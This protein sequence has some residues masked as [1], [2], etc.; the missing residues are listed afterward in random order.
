MKQQQKVRRAVR[1][2]VLLGKEFA[3][4]EA[5]YP[6]RTDSVPRGGAVDGAA[7][8]VLPLQQRIRMQRLRSLPCSAFII[9]SPLPSNKGVRSCGV[10]L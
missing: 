10:N 9:V 7:E 3:Q 4:W 1:H 5:F 6:R 2:E 8:D